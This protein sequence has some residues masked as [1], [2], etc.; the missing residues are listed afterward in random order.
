MH[1]LVQTHI[2]RPVDASAEASIR[3]CW[4]TGGKLPSRMNNLSVNSG[5]GESG[6]TVVL[7]RCFVQYF[8]QSRDMLGWLSDVQSHKVMLIKPRF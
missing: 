6:E 8:S 4:D 7:H 3:A 5:A 2:T 1:S